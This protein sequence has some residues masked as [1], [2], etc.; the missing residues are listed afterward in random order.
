M[1]SWVWRSGSIS[2]G[3]IINIQW[4]SKCSEL[5]TSL[6]LRGVLLKERLLVASCCGPG[7][8][9]GSHLGLLLIGSRETWFQSY[10]PSQPQWE[11]VTFFESLIIK[12]LFHLGCYSGKDD[13]FP[14]LFVKI[15]ELIRHHSL[16]E[17]NVFLI[18]SRGTQPRCSL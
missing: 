11:S 6:A 18:R 17:Q 3:S 12:M 9:K 1:K 15:Q 16:W 14:R 2:P 5:E 4:S 8:L 7:E 13:K 10:F